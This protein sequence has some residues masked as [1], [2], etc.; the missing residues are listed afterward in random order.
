[1]PKYRMHSGPFF[2]HRPSIRYGRCY[3]N[4]AADSKQI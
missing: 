3:G 1:M 4:Y 2:W